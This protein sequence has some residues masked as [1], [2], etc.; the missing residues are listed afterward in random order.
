MASFIDIAI[1]FFLFVHDIISRV[2][3]FFRHIFFGML[4]LKVRRIF[5]FWYIAKVIWFSGELLFTFNSLM[6]LC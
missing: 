5:D 2:E 3:F 4:S 6:G 1:V